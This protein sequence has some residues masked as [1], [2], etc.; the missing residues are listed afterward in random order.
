MSFPR[1]LLLAAPEGRTLAEMKWV[2]LSLELEVMVATQRKIEL[3]WIFLAFFWS[4]VLR[5]QP[6]AAL[7]HAE[8]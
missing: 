4:A 1:H 8:R 6:V 5:A 3:P 2:H 7:K